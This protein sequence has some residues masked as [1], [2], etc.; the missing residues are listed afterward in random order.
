MTSISLLV[1]NYRSAHLAPGAIRTARASSS[2]PLQVIVVDNS[3]QSEE[4]ESLRPIAD[5]MIAAPRN[6]G[7]AG[8]INAGRRAC[9]GDVIVVSNP[10][11]RFGDHAI[12]RLVDTDAAVAGP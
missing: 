6:L 9:D 5:V 7:Y 2:V 12:D 3:C 10:D 4:A 1:I 8:G 11:V